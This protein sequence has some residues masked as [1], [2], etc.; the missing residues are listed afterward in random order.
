MPA[1]VGAEGNDGDGD[2]RAAER[3]HGREDEEGALDREGHQVFFEEELGA[4]DQ[5]L[6]EA[7]GADAA[8]SPAVLDAADELCAP[9]APCRRRAI[10]VNDQHHDDLDER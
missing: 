7:E 3:D 4:V 1:D 9:A 5:G 2:E 10:S 8:G 6:E